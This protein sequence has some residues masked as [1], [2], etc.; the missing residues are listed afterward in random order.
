ME[1][2]F[3][4]ILTCSQFAF[5]LLAEAAQILEGQGA[6]LDWKMAVEAAIGALENGYLSESVDVKEAEVL[7]KEVA[8]NRAPPAIAHQVV[9]REKRCSR[10]PPSTSIGSRPG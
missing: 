8:M 7:R 6:N 3:N 5:V 2:D 9:N 1:I 10:P 4:A